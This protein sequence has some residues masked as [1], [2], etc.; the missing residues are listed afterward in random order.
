MLDRKYVFSLLIVENVLSA[1][2]VHVV[3]STVI[4]N[5][6]KE[7]KSGHIRFAAGFAF[8]RSHSVRIL[9][10]FLMI[11]PISSLCQRMSSGIIF[12]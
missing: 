6:N 2:A 12:S 8:I 10:T 7:C 4:Y 9:V 1:V 5:L 11:N 3:M